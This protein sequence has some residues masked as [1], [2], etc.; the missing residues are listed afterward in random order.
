VL[1]APIIIAVLA[2][3]LALLA[4]AGWRAEKSKRVF[5]NSAPR[6]VLYGLSLATLCSAW[7][8]FGA[9]GDTSNGSWLFLANALGPI[10]AITIG[11]PVW[12]RI[13]VLSKQENVG[14][15]ADFLAARYG[16]SR[17][18]GTLVTVVATL[19]AL[20]YIA[21]QLSIL[22][23]AWDF[24]GHGIASGPTQSLILVAL[25]VGFA[26]LFGARRP[27]LTQHNRGF[28][29]IIAVESIV[30][31][32]GL[33]CVAG[34]CLLLFAER[35]TPAKILDFIPSPLPALDFSFFTLALLCIVTAFTLP[36]QFHL[37]F[38]TLE[39]PAD[40]KAAAWIV[41]TYF[42]TWAGATLIIAAGIRAGFGMSGVDP[43]LQVM[44]IPMANASA[45]IALL[46][47]L[48][49]FSAG[50]AMVIVET[51]AVSA[52]V[53]NE[54][55][56]P[57]I[58]NR[59]QRDGSGRDVGQSILLVRRCIIVLIG[60]LSWLYFLAI[61]DVAGPTQLGQTA[62]TAFAQLLPALFGG[63]YWRRG[64]SN[65]AMAGI[66][67]GMLVWALGIAG[68]SLLLATPP[69]TA[70]DSLW[71][72]NG[73][74]LT[75]LTIFASLILNATLYVIVS[76][77][78]SPRLIDT[79]QANSFV[80]SPGRPEIRE[81]ELTAT[82][83]DLN[84]LLS[85]FL[86]ENEAKKALRDSQ[87]GTRIENWHEDRKATPGAIRA[88]ERLL[89]GAIGAPSARNVIAI[90]LAKGTQDAAEISQ[91]LDEAAHAVHFSRELLQTTLESLPQGVA[92]VDPELRLV[93][94]NARCIEL[95]NLPVEQ[96]YVGKYLPDLLD[97]HSG[98]FEPHPLRQQIGSHQ[99]DIRTRRAIDNEV[100]NPDGCTISLVGRKLGQEDYLLTFSDITDLKQAEKILSEDKELL[101]V[102]VEER[103]HELV[104]ANTAL[105]EAT[106]VAEQITSAQS[107]FVAAASHDLVQPLHAAR[108]FIGNALVSSQEDAAL[109]SLLEKADMAV[110]GAH[111][112]L[113]ALLNLS[114]L[115]TGSFKPTLEAVDIGAL[116]ASLAEEFSSQ[117]EARGLTLIVKPTTKWAN[118]ERDL[119]RSILQ[120]L[121][122]NALRYTAKGRV[123]VVTRFARNG[124]IRIEVR[125][126]GVGISPD[127]VETAFVE[128]SRLS[129]GRSMSDG[130][131]LGLSIVSRIAQ[132]LGHEVA[133]RSIPGLG[134]VFSV[135]VPSARP[136]PKSK[137]V[138]AKPA[139]LS[140]LRVLCVDDER[141]ILIGTTAL[142]E[143][144]GGVVT[145]ADSASAVSEDAS[146]WDVAI[147]DY[148]L[149]GE[150]G[151]DLLRR[152]GARVPI[153]ILV[154]A[155]PDG[156]WAW[157]LEKDGILLIQKPLAPLILQSIL[158]DAAKQISDTQSLV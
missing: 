102:R 103:T 51:T 122:L 141:D 64:H 68:P 28:V 23:Q 34:L 65:G 61:R 29:S 104:V 27:S 114:R 131:G 3:Y 107:R 40:I 42:L 35:G 56:L 132:V 135:T 14:S 54:I 119:L 145:A 62:L 80:L 33:L 94:W 2:G 143:R 79:I 37:G 19:G 133:V 13:A 8:Y 106:A 140:G 86:G 53:S 50:A 150:S 46:A 32:F 26:I 110:D 112:M 148:H 49:G 130:A 101:E 115:E 18:L 78:S 11:Y 109:R 39:D 91:I 38:V 58:S 127:K 128:F 83:G 84:R 81:T 12:R 108:L 126:T 144:W 70:L 87:A 149:G 147:A 45:W 7:T 36:R 55:V 76:L 59:L 120:N 98:V 156:A 129:E 158:S 116:L 73:E 90:A 155:T 10:L 6:S 22:A 74:K 41:P 17:A 66:L 121:M 47:L 52:M 43:H 85:Q 72:E 21:L 146:Q 4:F 124:T 100:L 136:V 118:T 5:S 89:A 125:D 96:A 75:N 30:K 24:V 20:P 67:S 44:G 138:H 93:V 31:L 154:T 63:I 88:V 123:V 111:K 99:D 57:L 97:I 60:I 134:S 92:V 82:L 71:P 153:R 77:R 69:P 1:S 139:K 117:A 95:L 142:I 151:L 48:G 9:V 15:L 152:L 113:R 25:L 16:K 157:D 137:I 105:A